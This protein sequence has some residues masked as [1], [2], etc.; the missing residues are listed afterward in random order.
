MV[1]VPAQSYLCGPRTRSATA[2]VT[3]SAASYLALASLAAQGC[4]FNPVGNQS[5]SD[6]A[7]SADGTSS[8]DGSTGTSSGDE[9]SSTHAASSMDGSSSSETGLPGCGDGLC[10]LEE[11]Q[12]GAPAC[13]DDCDACLPPPTPCHFEGD[14][15][16]EVDKGENV[17]N[18]VDCKPSFCGDGIVDAGE[19]CD[20]G[21][22]DY[23]EDFGLY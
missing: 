20:D 23:D 22:D 18:S 5:L 17:D 8:T 16:C 7:S 12:G 4:L 14:E 9:S 2:I 15:I 19:Q 10:S 3:I 6:E 21:D 13:L 11:F 1:S